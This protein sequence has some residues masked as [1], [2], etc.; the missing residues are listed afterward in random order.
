MAQNMDELVF[1]GSM[2]C[3]KI[4]RNKQYV[5]MH[6]TNRK[7]NPFLT[8]S[9]ASS[10]V[11][12]HKNVKEH[13]DKVEYPYLLIM[14]EKDVIVD[15]GAS[16]MWHEKTQSKVKAIKLMAGSYHELSKEPNNKDMFEAIL[17]FA[18]ERKVKNELKN[19]GDYD[20]KTVKI[21]ETM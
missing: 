2:Q 14:G 16:R 13:A 4:C 9:L 21:G 5:R 12:N 19:F 8:P 20:P 6:L 18:Q 1:T 3:H 17:K 10:I 7:A 15:N 11:Q